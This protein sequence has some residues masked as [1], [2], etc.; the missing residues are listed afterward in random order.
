[1]TYMKIYRRLL[2]FVSFVLLLQ[3][4]LPIGSV[5][6]T[7]LLNNPGFETSP[8]EGEDWDITSSNWD[9]ATMTH[10]TQDVQSGAYHLNYFNDASNTATETITVTQ[11]LKNLSAGDYTFSVDSMGG[12]DAKAGQVTL[13]ANDHQSDGFTTTGYGNWEVLSFDFSI[14]QTEDVTITLTID[15]PPGAWGYIDNVELTPATNQTPPVEADIHVEKVDGLRDDFIN[16]VDISSIIAL[17]NS[18]VTFYNDAGEEEDIFTI[19]KEKGVNYIRVKVW[20]DPYTAEGLGYGGGNNDVATAR[21]IGERATAAG[22]KVLVNFHY[23]D[24]WAD[25]AKQMAPKAWEGFSIAEKQDA[26]TTFTTETLKTLRAAGV[27][28]GMVQV[29]NETNSGMAGESGWADMLPLFKAG[30]QAVRNFDQSIDIALHFT[31]PE[32]GTYPNYAKQLDDAQIDYDIFASSYYSFWHGTLANLKSTLTAIADTYD[33]D[34]LVV[35]TSYA[36]TPEDGDGHENTIKGTEKNPPY[37]YTVQGQADA[38]RDVIATMA[39]IERGIGVFYWEPAWLPVGPPENLEEN[40]LKWEEDGS[41]WAASYATEYDPADAGKWYG[42]SAVDNQAWFDFDGNPLPTANIFNY[43][44]TGTVTPVTLESI[45]VP[46]VTIHVGEVIHYPTHVTYHYNDGS[47]QHVPVTFEPLT[48]TNLQPGTYETTG[49]TEQGDAVSLTIHVLAQNF[50]VDPSFELGSNAWQFTFNQ[51]PN[52]AYIKEGPG[53]SHTG[54]FHTHYWSEEMIDFTVTQQIDSLE[55]GIY[56]LSMHNQGGNFT[57]GTLLLFAETDTRYEQE[58]TVDG[59][60][61]WQQPTIQNIIVTGDSLTI[62]AHFIANSGSWGTLDDFSLIRTGD[63]PSDQTPEDDQDTPSDSETE[64]EDD[65]DD[66]PSNNEDDVDHGE[67]NTDDSDNSQTDTEEVTEDDT[68]ETDS[69][70]DQTND[71]TNTEVTDDTVI[72]DVTSLRQTDTHYV[73]NLTKPVITFTKAVT[74]ALD[75]PVLIQQPNLSLLIP[76]ENLVSTNAVSLQ[77]EQVENLSLQTNSPIYRF[78]LS[79][80]S[81]KLTFDKPIEV[82]FTVTEPVSNWDHLVI[83]YLSETGEILETIK[84]TSVSKT[85]QTVTGPLSHF[86]LYT[87][88]EVTPSD[89]GSTEAE[90]S[91]DAPNDSTMDDET[92]TDVPTSDQES[93]TTVEDPNATDQEEPNESSDSDESELDAGEQLPNTATVTFNFIMLGVLFIVASLFSFTYQKRK[94]NKQRMN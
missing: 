74:G 47:E 27:D 28:I 78:N 41:G 21:T 45:D 11:T 52:Q 94:M 38:M 55:P 32:K 67:E 59:W 43:V 8:Y 14:D 73:I 31:N 54:K 83:Q 5:Q 1:M 53:D 68:T 65:T 2:L 70:D 77:V 49:T 42:G 64:V 82:T 56:Q 4:I 66:R 34:V 13:K 81:G 12:S 19:L 26:I 33:K 39:S 48:G 50:V 17:E 22:M 89:S 36:Y 6:A 15:A 69:D 87:V 93:D 9:L 86:S 3:L 72:D 71:E 60:A 92:N 7:N 23:S 25:P 91:P 35:E 90:L 18:D 80:A 44:K 40:K 46:E 75:R 16:G 20:N 84:P 61:N 58:T 79:D 88:Q 63:L 37:P 51:A 24:F 29:G 30:T 85:N 76:Y 62:G 10:S 57:E